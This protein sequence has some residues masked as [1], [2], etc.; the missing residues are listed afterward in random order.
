MFPHASREQWQDRAGMNM[1]TMRAGLSGMALEFQDEWDYRMSLKRPFVL[2]YV[3]LGD[4]AAWHR[5]P[6]WKWPGVEFPLVVRDGWWEP[7]RQ[8]VVAFALPPTGKTTPGPPVI[9]YISR[10]K[11]GR[12]LKVADHTSLVKELR[13]LGQ[14]YG[15]EVCDFISQWIVLK[16]LQIQIPLMEEMGREDQITLLSRTTILLGVHGNGLSGQMWLEPSPRTT[17]IEIFFPTGFAYDYEYTARSLG[18]K[19]YG[20]WDDKYFTAPDLPP[21][22]LHTWLGVIIAYV[23]HSQCSE[24]LS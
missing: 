11:T 24:G 10:Q 3:V 4:R 17:V 21:S 13:N 9:T 22:K 1:W 12:R 20:I 18:H 14:E 5:G 23:L 2:E 7:V 8:S 16:H 6:F 19:H 15:Y